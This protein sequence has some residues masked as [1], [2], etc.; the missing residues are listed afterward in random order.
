MSEVFISVKIRYLL[1]GYILPLKKSEGLPGSIGRAFHL[2]PS[3]YR[4][5]T[6]RLRRPMRSYVSLA[7]HLS[8][9]RFVATRSHMRLRT[10]SA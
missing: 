10:I 7:P 4:R 6:R 5:F 1:A 2:L 8:I 3:G 9:R